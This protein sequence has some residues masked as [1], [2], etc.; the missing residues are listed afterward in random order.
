[1]NTSGKDE[2]GTLLH[3]LQSQ[4]MDKGR[5]NLNFKMEIAHLRERLSSFIGTSGDVKAFELEANNFQ[6]KKSLM[7]LEQEHKT[8]V[9]EKNQMEQ[10]CGR[11]MKNMVKL[12]KAWRVSLDENEAL[13][14]TLVSTQEQHQAIESASLQ[15]R[16]TLNETTARLRTANA[17]VVTVQQ[18][19]QHLAQENQHVQN[20]LTELQS[21]VDRMTQSRQDVH[22][23]SRHT[24]MEY[25]SKFQASVE[26]EAKLR[27][28][29]IGLQSECQ[30]L[31]NHFDILQAEAAQD[32]AKVLLLT[33]EK[34]TYVIQCIS[35]VENDIRITE[36]STH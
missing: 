4:L 1:M 18:E 28:Q 5:E 35:T 29:V 23:S 33:E 34:S 8:I 32:Q 36:S 20:Q 26:Q 7:N 31:Q 13:K 6:L 25:K 27:G 19:N 10:K 2:H 14:K 11:A 16:E 21:Q 17:S 12:D 15:M 3:T 22:A 24:E 9:G 30:C